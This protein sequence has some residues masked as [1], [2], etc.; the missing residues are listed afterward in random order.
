[1]TLDG[2]GPGVNVTGVSP[3]VGDVVPLTVRVDVERGGARLTDGLGSDPDGP[4]VASLLKAGSCG[5]AIAAPNP[6]PSLTTVTS[7]DGLTVLTAGDIVGYL[8]YPVTAT[9]LG[10]WGALNLTGPAPPSAR[11]SLDPTALGF[12]SGTFAGL[13]GL[14]PGTGGNCGP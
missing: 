10:S 12:P 3:A 11:G 2:G 6:A 5:L 9:G 13:S 14:P 7:T 1:M 8:Q 4:A